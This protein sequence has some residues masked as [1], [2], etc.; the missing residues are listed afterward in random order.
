LELAMRGGAQTRLSRRTVVIGAA[1]ALG[2]GMAATGAPHH[3]H[4]ADHLVHTPAELSEAIASAQPGDTITM[5]TGVWR[6]IAIVFRTNG[7]ETAPVT[8][9]AQTRGGVIISGTSYLQLVGDHL[10]VDG[11]D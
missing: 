1:G 9:R 7:T 3:A 5:A 2:L 11:L 8:L 6:D 4:A 10:V